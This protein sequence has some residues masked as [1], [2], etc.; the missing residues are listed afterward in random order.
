MTRKLLF[1]GVAFAAAILALVALGSQ[2]LTSDQL[3]AAPNEIGKT[4]AVEPKPADNSDLAVDMTNWQET[5]VTLGPGTKFRK[6]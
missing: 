2:V 1:G 6:K 4:H 5:R 3:S